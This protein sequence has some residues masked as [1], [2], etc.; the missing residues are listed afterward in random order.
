VKRRYGQYDCD[1]HAGG[2]RVRKYLSGNLEVAR[3]LLNEFRARADR[4]EFGL[5]DNDTRSRTSRSSSSSIV[6]RR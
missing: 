4:A 6:N 1:F 3:Q 2:R 5:L